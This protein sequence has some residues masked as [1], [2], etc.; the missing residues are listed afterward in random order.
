MNGENVKR[1]AGILKLQHCQCKFFDSFIGLTTVRCQN[2]EA[3][4]EN[5]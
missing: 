2:K 4:N 3:G 5:I 1:I